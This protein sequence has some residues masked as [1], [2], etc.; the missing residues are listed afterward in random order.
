LLGRAERRLFWSVAHFF[1]ISLHLRL[2]HRFPRDEV[3]FL[4]EFSFPQAVG[5][6][7]NFSFNGGQRRG[8]TAAG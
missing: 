8:V 3:D 4:L 2:I 1:C 7:A 5:F 6:G